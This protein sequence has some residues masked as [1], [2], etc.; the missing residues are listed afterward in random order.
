MPTATSFNWTFPWQQMVG[1]FNSFIGM[2]STPVALGV[3]LI[4]VFA[5]ASFIVGLV[6]KAKQEKA[7]D[8][9]MASGEVRDIF[10]AV[11]NP[12]GEEPDFDDY[13]EE[14]QRE[15]VHEY[16]FGEPAWLED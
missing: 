16:L 8:E 6:Q 13:T 2:L 14:E 15:I 12:G 4:L 3:A 11:P 1:A 7:V 10:D 9:A 5:V